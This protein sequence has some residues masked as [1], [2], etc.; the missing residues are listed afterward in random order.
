[1]T[2]AACCYCGETFA[3]PDLRP[4]GPEGA[5]TCHPCAVATPER[6]AV[7]AAMFAVQVEAAAAA[8]DGFA[9]ID[10]STSDGPQPGT[11]RR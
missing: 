4:Y 2:R 5:L 11:F 3:A 7:T 6:E 1:M 9:V 8:G 10:A